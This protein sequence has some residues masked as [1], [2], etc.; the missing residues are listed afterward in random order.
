VSRGFS[1]FV[2]FVLSLFML[3]VGALVVVPVERASADGLE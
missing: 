2:A 1:A 3:L